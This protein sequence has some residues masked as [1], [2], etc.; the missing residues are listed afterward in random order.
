MKLNIDPFKC[1]VCDKIKES[2]NHW[3]VVFRDGPFLAV[4]PWERSEEAER[5]FGGARFDVCGIEHLH[6]IISKLV[7]EVK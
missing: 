5:V 7:G 6:A 3:W 4:A 2:S 1:D